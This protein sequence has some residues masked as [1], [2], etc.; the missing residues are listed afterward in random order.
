MAID[1]LDEGLNDRIPRLYRHDMEFF[2]WV[3]SYI[4]VAK[5]EYKNHAIEI[6]PLS[7]VEAWFKDDDQRIAKNHFANLHYHYVP[8]QPPTLTLPW[9]L[10]IPVA[11]LNSP[12]VPVPS[13][14]YLA[15]FNRIRKSIADGRDLNPTVNKRRDSLTS[16]KW[17]TQEE[18]L[19]S[20]IEPLEKLPEIDSPHSGR[21][22][23][24]LW[25]HGGR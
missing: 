10:A 12:L 6:S 1:M 18:M 21:R 24:R 5:I 2:V 13:Q 20:F 23:C 17:M 19:I 9:K 22:I 14:Q 11:H 8:Q 4:T 15:G 16:Q 3:L 25:G 7:E